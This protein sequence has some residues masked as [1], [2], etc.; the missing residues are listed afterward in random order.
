MKLLTDIP[1]T[2]AEPLYEIMQG[3]EKCLLLFTAV[4]LGV[5]NC[6]ETP[7]TAET[8]AGE[9]KTDLKLT[10][11]FLNSLVAIGLLTKQ[12]C[13]YCNTFLASAYL[14]RKSPFYQGNLLSL[15]KKGRQQR[16]SKLGDCLREGLTVPDEKQE[17]VFDRGFTLA[18]AEGA[19]RGG[20]QEALKIVSSL[21]EFPNA[22][23]LLDLGGGHGLYGIGFCQIN[24]KLQSFV[25]DMPAVLEITREFIAKYQMQ[26][27]VHAIEGDFTRDDWGGSYDIILAS[28]A[29]YKP[30]ELLLPVLQKVKDSLNEGGIFITKQWTIN[31]ERTGPVTT[32]L[33][34]LMVSLQNSFP[35]YTYNDKE[36]VSILEEAGFSRIEVF[37]TSTASKPSCIIVSRKEHE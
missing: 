35:F 33:W 23:K 14:V 3:S 29:L 22:T 19:M 9:L 34:D 2:D 5:F 4:E 16:W 1:G 27:R 21:P 11:K 6:L 32:V 31:K 15:M 26:D 17:K 7:K 13:L 8:T 37:D 36:F 28:D 25:F 10:V 18:M 12:N 20:L 24:P 30:K